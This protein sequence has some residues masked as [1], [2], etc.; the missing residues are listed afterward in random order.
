MNGLTRLTPLL[1][2]VTILGLRHLAIDPLQAREKPPAGIVTFTTID[3][4]RNMLQQL[5]ITKLRPGPSG[6]EAAPNHANF[7]EAL[8][9]PFPHLPELLVCRD[10]TVVKTKE[11]WIAKRRPEIARAYCTQL[12]FDPAEAVVQDHAIAVVQDVVRRYAIDAVHLDDYFYPYPD[13][14]CPG[15]AFPDS[16]GFARYR[17]AGGALARDDWR[18]DNVNRFVERLYRDIRALRIYEGATEVQRLLVGREML[19]AH[20]KG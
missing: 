18:R 6:N 11:E 4:H 2:L 17:A 8:A 16:A 3:D 13:T 1:I 5:G 19:K 15:L 9:N 10:G 14:R 12:W 20:A 7:D